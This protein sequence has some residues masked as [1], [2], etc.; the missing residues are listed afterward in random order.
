MLPEQL[1]QNETETM[2]RISKNVSGKQVLLVTEQIS[3][4]QCT[5]SVI[6]HYLFHILQAAGANVIHHDVNIDARTKRSFDIGIYTHY[7]TSSRL[8]SRRA[9]ST[10]KTMRK[11]CK[12][13]S[14]YANLVPDMEVSCDQYF[15]SRSCFA[16]RNNKWYEWW[17]F[18]KPPKNKFKRAIYIG[19]GIDPYLLKPEQ[20]EF[21]VCLDA[22]F[23]WPIKQARE[24]KSDLERRNIVVKPVGFND[25]TWQVPKLSFQKIAKLYNSTSVFVSTIPGIYEMPAVEAQ[26]A[27]NYVIS[28]QD[29]L[30]RELCCPESSCICDSPEQ[31][32]EAVLQIRET[33]DPSVPR[34]FVS[35]WTWTNI[36]EKMSRSWSLS[37][38]SSLC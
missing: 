24:I 36:V 14:F 2:G 10:L 23:R 38:F 34:G 26:C 1:I 27:G 32:I 29:C 33:Y 17:Q 6:G 35:D 21:A 9:R 15:L 37:S 18:T 22:R 12:N 25:K 4:P 19:R 5:Y 11:A 28:Y 13:L 7:E 30:P 16:N 20:S 31:A 3:K 8:R